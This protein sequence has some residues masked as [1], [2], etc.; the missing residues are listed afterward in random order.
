MDISSKNNW[1]WSSVASHVIHEVPLHEVKL[2]VCCTMNPKQITG[3][4]FYE[5]TINSDR[6]M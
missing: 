3:S 1:Y 4:I 6:Y 5:E 2:G